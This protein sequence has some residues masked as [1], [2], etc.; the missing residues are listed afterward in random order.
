MG[1]PHIPATSGHHVLLTLLPILS[2]S[3]THWDSLLCSDF[4]QIK[5]GSLSPH[6]SGNYSKI[7]PSHPLKICSL[8]NGNRNK[9]NVLQTPSASFNHT[10]MQ[11]SRHF[12]S[13]QHERGKDSVDTIIS[14]VSF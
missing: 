10:G 11:H 1:S 4:K 7:E 14:S 2:C 13:G 5:Q 8:S 12:S 9:G 6:P 3:H